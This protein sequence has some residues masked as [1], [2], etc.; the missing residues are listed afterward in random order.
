VVDVRGRADDGRVR[1]KT[2]E[3]V[4]GG[5]GGSGGGDGNGCDAEAAEAGG[6]GGEARVRERAETSPDRRRAAAVEAG[7]WWASVAVYSGTRRP[8][9]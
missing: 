6:G 4:A 1:G 7:F 2:E 3:R 5:S 9:S 8:V